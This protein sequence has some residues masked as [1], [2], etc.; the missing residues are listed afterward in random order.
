MNN[1]ENK[2]LDPDFDMVALY[3]MSFI[4]NSIL[5]GWTVKKLNNSKFEFSNNKDELKKEYHLDNFLKKFIKSNLNINQ[6]INGDLL[7]E[8]DGYKDNL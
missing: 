5:N 2:N 6:I 7:N 1:I 4:Y 3:K 8:T